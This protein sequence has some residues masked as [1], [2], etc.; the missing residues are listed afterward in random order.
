MRTK[1]IDEEEKRIMEDLKKVDSILKK[2][3]RE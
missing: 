1:E 2:E 3:E